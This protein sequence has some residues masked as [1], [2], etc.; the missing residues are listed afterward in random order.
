MGLWENIGKWGGGYLGTVAAPIAGTYAGAKLGGNLGRAVDKKGL[1][2]AVNDVWGSLFPGAP[3]Q[4]EGNDPGVDPSEEENAKFREQLAAFM[5][6][7]SKPVDMNDPYV[8]QI[9]R[10]AGAQA[11]QA[12]YANGVEGPYSKAAAEQASFGARLQYAQQENARRQS[13][14]LQAMNIEGNR[15]G[16]MAALREKAR[17]FDQS[18]QADAYNNQYAQG[19][20]LWKTVGGV[21]GG[22]GGAIIGSLVAPGIGT[23]VGAT[24]GA[25]LGSGLSGSLAGA[26]SPYRPP[27]ASRR[28][29]RGI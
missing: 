2:G 24:A 4:A 9:A 22:L 21:A 10:S 20:D 27:S 23:A 26:A 6:E 14:K 11:E 29:Y 13:A 18:V 7:M 16:Q 15:L 1:G 3:A 25:S 28:Q 19:Q 8:Q 5:E 17:Q 12:M